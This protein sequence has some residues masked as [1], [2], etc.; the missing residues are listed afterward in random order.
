MSF[1]QTKKPT[2]PITD[3]DGWDRGRLARNQREARTILINL[4]LSGCEEAGET[5]AVPVDAVSVCRYRRS[6]GAFAGPYA[7]IVPPKP[8]AQP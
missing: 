4:D 2:S 8:T 7:M 3:R 1:S 5:P 6:L